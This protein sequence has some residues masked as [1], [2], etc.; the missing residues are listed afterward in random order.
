MRLWREIQSI[1][2]EEVTVSEVFDP[3]KAGAELRRT[4]AL[5]R[6]IWRSLRRDDIL[7]LA[8][9]LAFKTLLAL[10]PVLAISLAV[11]AML[12]GGSGEAETY[13]DR[14]VDAI[15][16][17]LPSISAM[18]E[19]VAQIH[20]FAKNARTVLGIGFL[21]LFWTAFSLLNAIEGSFNR[22]W[23]VHERR[24]VLGRVNA[25]VATLVIVPVLMVMSVVMMS[26]LR[27]AAEEVLGDRPHQISEASSD[28]PD[29]R[30][31]P[32]EEPA[33]EVQADSP[34]PS[35]PT[36]STWRETIL[37]VILTA[38]SV[39]MTCLA[40]TALFY[41]MPNTVVRL[42]AALAGGVLSGLT[43]EIAKLL[44][45]TYASHVVDNYTRIYGPLLAIPLFL[46]W[47]WLVWIFI[48]IGAEV[49]FTLQNFR[50]LAVRAEL[51]KRGIQNRLYLAV[52][53]VLRACRY[54]REGETP[55]EFVDCAAEELEVP[56]YM[57]R[58]LVTALVDGNVL[59][60]IIPEE[61]SYVP[62]K[63]IHRLTV[64][65][66]IQA[67]QN[68]PLEVPAGSQDPVR[69]RLARLFGR[70]NAA[71]EETLGSVTFA[72]LVES[73]GTTRCSD[74][75]AASEEDA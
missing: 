30:S 65:E 63:D 51:E 23:Q 29:T 8:A 37:H 11:V 70:V 40:M 35:P 20:Q 26:F 17:K 75:E 19:V 74:E 12:D 18:D 6:E 21:F 31:E 43:F 22:I 64:S 28:S 24:S 71:R 56:P 9:S 16:D 52:R 59:R 57:V 1:F 32:V 61:E 3:S 66:V 14:F 42:R 53:I 48:L 69:A 60:Q 25:F 72:D 46:L 50:D 7:N 68:D 44:F 62:A 36:E 38:A 10:V 34:A 2:R 47:I 27:G 15:K 45:R 49:A 41:L 5:I 55:S 54:F 67:I 73:Q 33:S 13:T 58:E 39:M 4:L